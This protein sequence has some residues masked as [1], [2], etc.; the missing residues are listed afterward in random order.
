MFLTISFRGKVA[1]FMFLRLLELIGASVDMIGTLDIAQRI[2]NWSKIGFEGIMESS[3]SIYEGYSYS[4]EVIPFHSLV[5]PIFLA[6]LSSNNEIF[7]RSS[8]HV[9]LYTSGCI[10]Q[11]TFLSLSVFHTLTKKGFEYA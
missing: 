11:F 9:N 6:S 7:K 8:Y 2:D 3:T 5:F 4:V 1:V 10:F